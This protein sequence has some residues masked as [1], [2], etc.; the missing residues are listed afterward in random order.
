MVAGQLRPGS[1]Y[2]ACRKLSSIWREVTQSPLGA[3]LDHFIAAAAE[4]GFSQRVRVGIAAQIVARLLIQTG[5]PLHQLTLG[6]LAE[7]AAACRQHGRGWRSYRSALHSTH[8]VLFHLGILDQPPPPH[9]G[10]D[11]LERRVAGVA[12]PLHARFVAYL[13]RK[14]VTCTA[15]TVSSLA[16]RLAHFGR[17]LA[18]VDPALGSLAELDRCRHIE[19]YLVA[20][21]QATSRGGGRLSV[22]EQARRT[23]A[24]AGFLAEIAEWGWPDAPARLL[25]R[26]DVPRQPQPLPRYLPPDADRRLAEA[27]AAAPP[28]SRLA[29]DACLLQRACGLRVGELLT[30]SSTASTRSTAR[31]PG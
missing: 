14:R 4:L 8:H 28:A 11:P 13:E 10:R 20:L 26:S 27:L 9:H 18:Q 1:D 24:V 29:A 31:T 2:L 25:H 7:L 21:R 17:F 16:T 6:D 30:S 19:P 22:A 23:Y 15:H 5:R 3:D 12:A